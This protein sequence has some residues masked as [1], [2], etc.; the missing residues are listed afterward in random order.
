MKKP[1]LRAALLSLAAASLAVLLWVRVSERQASVS[2]VEV[3]PAGPPVLVV[4]VSGGGSG[5]IQSLARRASVVDQERAIGTPILQVDSGDFLPAD[6][7]EARHS[8]RTVL[9]AMARM[10]MDAVTPG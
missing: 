9:H 4:F 2:P 7:G 5:A 3:I 1:M 8:A 10:G 6:A